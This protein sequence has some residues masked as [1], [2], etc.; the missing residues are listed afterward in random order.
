MRNIG[1]TEF[2]PRFF[3]TGTDTD[4]GKTVIAS[5]LVAGLKAAYWKPVQSGLEEMTDTEVVQ[6][7]SGLPAKHFFPDTYRLKTPLSPHASAALEGVTIELD[8]F[9]LPDADGF[10]NLIVEGAGGIMVPLNDRQY[11]L[12]LMKQLNLPVLLVTRSSLGTINHAL[13]SLDMLRKSGLT[14]LGVVINGPL[15]PGNRDAIEHFGKVRV[16]AEIEPIDDLSPESLLDVFK[17]KF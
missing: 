14:V 1:K 5:I 16:C 9:I 17:N 8:R 3:I 7:M 4:I 6:S 2:P 13:L 10:P 15:N 12:D 11:M